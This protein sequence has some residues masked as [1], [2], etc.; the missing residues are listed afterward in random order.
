M[1]NDSLKQHLLSLLPE[2]TFNENR[3]FIE[4]LVPADQLH[5]FCVS[6]KSAPDMQFDYLIS[7]TAVDRKDH[8]M[9]V[10]HI[11]STA[12]RHLLVVKT[13]IDDLVQPRIDSLSDIWKTAEYHEREIYD[14]F[15]IEFRNHPDMRRLF[16]EDGYGFPLRK[17]FTDESRMI[18]K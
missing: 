15:G 14:L 1:D 11:T 10:S 12:F 18:V 5:S 17:S 6:L 9:M 4:V 16:L 7:L 3:Q 13:R 2:L 8:F